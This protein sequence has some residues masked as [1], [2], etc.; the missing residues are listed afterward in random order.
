[1]KKKQQQATKD[2]IANGGK[3]NKNKNN[4]NGKKSDESGSDEDSKDVQV[5]FVTGKAGNGQT[6]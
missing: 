5:Q 3:N 2:A 4:K 6:N 1:M